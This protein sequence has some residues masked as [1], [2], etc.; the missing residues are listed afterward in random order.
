MLFLKIKI[1]PKYPSP[2]KKK[3]A[4]I[5]STMK[6]K[7]LI[8]KVA[9]GKSSTA[10]IGEATVFQ[11]HAWI[12]GMHHLKQQFEIQKPHDKQQARRQPTV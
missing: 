9:N 2:Q 1:L 5:N 11:G 7:L 12:I 8:D 3:S 4:N 10:N 6:N